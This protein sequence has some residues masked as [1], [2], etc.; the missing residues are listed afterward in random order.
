MGGQFSEGSEF[1]EIAIINFTS[2]F[3]LIADFG[4]DWK[5]LYHLL[6][7]NYVFS[8][9]CFIKGFLIAFYF[10]NSL[11]VWKLTQVSIKIS[12]ISC[13]SFSFKLNNKKKVPLEK[14]G[15]E[16][17]LQKNFT[18]EGVDN[19][20]GIWNREGL[21][22]NEWGKIEGGYDP[23]RNHGFLKYSLKNSFGKT[24]ITK[25]FSLKVSEI[26]IRAKFLYFLTSFKI[27]F[28]KNHNFLND[29]LE[30]EL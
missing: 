4:A 19:S 24:A 10:T 30:T 6:F 18:G 21:T 9:F 1:L 20:Y 26:R 5:I 2:R 27:T 28:S 25:F 12:Q 8:L 29:F 17:G 22:R 16:R 14:Y 23:Q 3:Y 15:L 7:F 13:F 11:F